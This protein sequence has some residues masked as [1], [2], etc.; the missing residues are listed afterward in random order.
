MSAFRH[1]FTIHCYSFA[2]LFLLYSL[3]AMGGLFPELAMKE[4][5]LLY[6]MTAGIA[7][8]MAATDRL[9]LRSNGLIAAVRLLDVAAV[10]FAIGLPSGFIPLEADIILYVLGLMAVIFVSITGLFMIKDSAEATAIN[11]RLTKRKRILNAEKDKE[12]EDEHEADH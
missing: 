8:L 9:P 6:A 12:D 2:I 4:G 3:F 1:Y 11:E 7:L 5:M 10:V